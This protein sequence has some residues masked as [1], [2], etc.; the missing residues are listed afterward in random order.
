MYTVSDEY[1]EAMKRPVQRHR[2]KGT[3]GGTPFTEDHILSGSFT[4]SGQCSDNSM[5]QIGQVYTTELKITLLNRLHLSRYTIKGAEIAPSF[6]LRLESGEYEYIPLGI[7]TVSKASWGASGVEITAYDNMSKL[8]RKFSSS[9]LSGKPYELLTV[10][11]AN[12]GL[13]LAMKAA[14][15][16]AFA[17][18]TATLT[19]YSENNVETW[20]DCVGWIAQAL[21]CNVFADRRGRIYLRA[22][23]QE[24]AD[25]I[26]TEHRFTGSKFDDFE[27]R[28]TGISVVN[29]ADQMT[30]YYALEE[31]DALTYNLGSNPFLQ[32]ENS[33]LMCRQILSAMQQIR[34]VPFSVDMIGNPA[35]GLM[36]VLRFE[37][38]FA[39]GEKVSCITKYT[40]HYNAKYTCSGVGSDPALATANSKSDKNIAGLMAQV[41]AI[42]NSINRLIY[43]YNTGAIIVGQDEQT[44]GML[45]YYISQRADVEGHFLMTYTASE[46][47]HMT[48]RIYDQLT[49]E[50]YSPLEYDIPEGEGS[51][52]I[53]HAYLNRDVGIH[54]VYV[55]VKV[56]SGTLTVNTRGAFFTIDAGN[57]AQAVDDISMDVRDITMRQI[58]E[59]NG[60]DQIWI[61]GIEEGK[62]LVSRRDYQE[63]YT[64]AP[65]WTG[66]YTAG[67]AI[68]AAIEFDGTW[69]LRKEQENY[70][71]ETEDQPWYFWIDPDG[72]LYAQDGENE[73][74][75]IVL[76]ED[77]VT[78][79]ACR[80]YSST[81]FPD[82]DQGLVAAYIRSDRKVYYR[83]YVLNTETGEKQWLGEVPLMP[84]EEWDDVRVHRLNDYRLSFVLTNSDH[85]LWL[86]TERTYVNQAAPPQ[87]KTDYL[88][89]DWN[90]VS[91]V[92]TDHSYRGTERPF[93]GDPRQTVFIIDFACDVFLYEKPYEIITTTVNGN[94]YSGKYTFKTEGNSLIIT[95][96]QA[97]SGIV[98]ITVRPWVH[99]LIGNGINYMFTGST[100]YNWEVVSRIVAPVQTEEREDVMGSN[101]V[102]ISIL[103]IKTIKVS[104][105]ETRQDDLQVPNLQIDVKE[106][107]TGR[108]ASEESR[109]DVLAGAGIQ[110]T[111]TQTGDKPI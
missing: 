26:D 29:M 63:S 52:G 49:E 62:M 68:D 36:D 80:G 27:T 78:V 72:V 53:P 38:G 97:I 34:Y 64:S 10:A 55:T 22:Y 100:T 4:I 81:L 69:V 88:S 39:D 73:A 61:I 50:L 104:Q 48:I 32:G 93:E 89:H 65:T 13:E 101:S 56:L 51:I 105:K 77:A 33:E 87:L 71:L 17:N 106:L 25:V 60:P 40:F 79:K 9:T 86:M 7:F 102:T 19:I 14:D 35:Y 24:P 82:Q 37:G 70:T 28:Y 30:N 98:A 66:V 5:V 15:F 67:K 96:E 90:G 54:S 108:Y 95:F 103:P 3:I 45:T 110:I 109:S 44:M 91:V 23:G 6:G 1:R 16:E 107:K 83:Q 2:V 31:D 84:G 47:T 57:F 99:Y 74:S 11:C 12:C 20:R 85:N 75:R 8:D 111:V 21:A 46:S 42:T 59:S 58:L 94:A 41:S 92:S 18:G 43:D 76:A